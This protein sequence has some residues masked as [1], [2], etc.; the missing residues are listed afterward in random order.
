MLRGFLR[1][2]FK[3]CFQLKVFRKDL[4]PKEGPALIMPN[5]VSF[6]DG[7]L[8]YAFLPKTT[9]FVINREI[10]A[11]L[12][13][14]LRF[15]RYIEIDPLNPFS[16]KEVIR[17]VT[18]GEVAVIF[19]EGRIT[20]TGGLMKVYGGVGMIALRTGA[21]IVPVILR[22]PEMTPFSRL[23]G[24]KKKWFPPM[25][26]HVFPSVKATIEPGKS[27]RQAKSDCTQ[28]LLRILQESF[29][30][31]RQESEIEENFY[32]M[33]YQAGKK[34]GMSRAILE[35]PM[36]KFSYRKLLIGS[37]ALGQVLR[38]RKE[39]SPLGILMPNSRA[40]VVAIFASASA[41]LTPAVLNFTV[42]G[43]TLRHSL[44]IGKIKTVLTS[45]LFVEKTGLDP[46]IEEISKESQIVYLEDL[47][48]TIGFLGKMKAALAV[49]FGIDET[50]TSNDVI[51]FTS[52]SESAPKGVVLSQRGILCNIHQIS[53]V[54]S[55][56]A[57]DRMLNPLPIFHSF[58][59]TAGTLLPLLSGI[60]SYI[61]PSPL[62]YRVIPEVAY[63]KNITVLLG[64]P[65]FLYGYARMASPIDFYS[66]RYVLA[67]GE[68][69]QGE[70]RQ[71]WQDKF[72][73]RLMEGY[74]AT[75]TGPVLAVNT[76]LFYQSG[77]VGVLMPGMKSLLTPVEG[78]EKG[79]S[80]SVRGPNVMRGYL[81]EGK[82]F[83]PLEGW[84]DTGDVVAVGADGQMMIQA[85]LKRFAKI[86][87]EMV[88][89]DSVEKWVSGYSSAKRHGTVSLPDMRKGEKIL[90]YTTDV[91]L[92]MEGL[93][94]H[95]SQQNLTMLSLPSQI[96]YKDNLPLLVTG[97]IDYRT[98][99]QW[100]LQES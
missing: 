17:R 1:G 41:G 31:S 38:E 86:S 95:W 72:G 45:R 62:H 9:T 97:K 84:Y 89:L 47:A 83:E 77:A 50:H 49:F 54:I 36:G 57:A 6:L 63:D 85:R 25:S 10:A 100:K 27:F 61:Y 44:E 94:S 28:W 66:V 67:G 96:I 90:L 78:I 74:G 32:D 70:V 58:G 18:A 75:E 24:I 11:K 19:P 81:R 39:S 52:G 7:I 59:L 37:R 5:H 35:D 92:T 56:T 42:G 80:L 13:H 69:L 15:F 82:G 16:L 4:L 40:A 68:K 29:F 51:L 88:S 55:Y 21:P 2:I 8:L 43:E 71:L 48:K 3:I 98:L 76:P 91:N 34:Y 33:L 26:I 73:I 79:G 93:R 30:S 65:T 20:T 23:Q 87:G 64:T 22:G 46:L 99:N 53:A 12:H 14:F 60:Y